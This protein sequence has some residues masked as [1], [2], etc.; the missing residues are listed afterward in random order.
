MRQYFPNPYKP[1]SRN[2]KVELDFSDSV[3]KADLK[4]ATGVDILNLAVKSGL[5]IFRP[6]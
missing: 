1:S 2:V 4:E 3:A 6:K 5:V